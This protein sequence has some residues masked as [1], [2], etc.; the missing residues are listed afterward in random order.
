MPNN[1]IKINN[2]YEI[3]LISFVIC[4]VACMFIF[5][6]WGIELIKAEFD[7][8]KLVIGSIIIGNIIGQ[9]KEYDKNRILVITIYCVCMLVLFFMYFSLDIFQNTITDNIKN[10]DIVQQVK[11]LKQDQIKDQKK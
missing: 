3:I 6:N 10:E 9:I 1:S 8:G 11:D 5:K 2:F 4:S 7:L